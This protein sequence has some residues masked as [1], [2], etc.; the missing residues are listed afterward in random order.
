MTKAL[1]AAGSAGLG[2]LLTLAAIEAFLRLSGAVLPSF[3]RDDERFGRV[4]RPDTPLLFVNEGFHLGRTNEWGYLGPGPGPG[5]AG[6]PDGELR[7]ALLG[8]SFVEGFQVFDRRHFRSRLEAALNADPARPVRVMNFGFSGFNFARSADY[9]DAYVSRFAPDLV[10]FF[11]GIDDFVQESTD[12][13][14]RFR[15]EGDS[16][17]ADLSFRESPAFRRKQA[18]S[19]ARDFSFYT[20]L[21]KCVQLVKEGRAGVLV[22][23]KLHPAYD[24]PQAETDWVE[25][26]ADRSDPARE[27][28]NRRFIEKLGRWNDAGRPKVAFVAKRPLEGRYREW[29]E[30]AGLPILDP[31]PALRESRERGIDPNWWPVTKRRG[32]WNDAG[33]GIIARELAA[34]VRAL[35]DGTG[36]IAAAGAP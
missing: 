12:L 8:D 5:A 26:A 28:V 19:A 18:V 29:I 15:A 21:R 7:V 34:P 6:G 32:H 31:T 35:L 23:D 2:L 25:A 30:E 4:L 3:V 10:L 9:A 17:V 36:G 14:P 20:L 22:L 11:A 16:V 24:A 1:R 27:A 13:G 33:H